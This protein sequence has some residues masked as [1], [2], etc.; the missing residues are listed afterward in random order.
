MVNSLMTKE[1]RIYNELKSSFFNKLCWEN[2]TATWKM[3]QTGLLYH[4]VYQ[5]KFKM[6]YRLKCKA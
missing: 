1:I 2:W 4:T 5:N 3:N 6:D